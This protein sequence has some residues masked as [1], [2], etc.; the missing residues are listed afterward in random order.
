MSTGPGT[1]GT[2]PAAVYDVVVAGAGPAG[3]MAATILARGGAR[4]LLLDRARFPRDKL[5]GDTLNPGA[6]AVLRRHGLDAADGGLPITGMR[7]TGPGGVGVA[8]TYPGGRTGRALIR[9]TFDD[10]MVRGAAAAGAEV[11]DGVLVQGPL[12]DERGG[13][14]GV[15]VRR[16]SSGTIEVPAALVIA[17]DGRHSRLARARSLARHADR[18]RRWAVGAYFTGVSGMTARGEMHVRPDYYIGVAPL[19]GGLT[20]ACAVT[21]DRGRLREPTGLLADCLRHEP[22]LAERFVSARMVGRPMVLGPLAVECTAPGARGLLLAGDA[23]GFIDPMTGD[24]LRFALR[25]GELAAVEALRALASGAADAHLRL[26]AERHREFASKWRFNRALRQ[27]AGCADAVRLACFAT[28]LSSWPISRVIRY[29]GD[30]S[31]A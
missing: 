11:E 16:G 10:A 29:A 18:P 4:V 12:L 28:R 25:G 24:G 7:V 27:L 21:A 17:A 9:R 31:A 22:E 13:V 30:L 5:C 1:R 19:P 26:A 23:A 15:S 2:T 20:N 8:V 3:C 14:R 6:M